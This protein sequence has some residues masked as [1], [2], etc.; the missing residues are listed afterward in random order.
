MKTALVI[1]NG[2]Q[3]PYYLVDHAISWA[4]KNDGDLHGLFVY[5]DKEPREGYIFPSDIDPAENLYN[6]SD[7]EQV[8]VGVIHAQI[9]LFRD[10]A[11]GK[12]ISVQTEELISPSLED[13][14]EI[15]EAASILFIDAVSDKSYLLACTSFDFKDLIEESKCPV[16]MVYDNR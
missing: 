10:M 1:F 13:I 11:K 6:K 5:S 16:E 7:A 8:N 4:A 3:F 2:I 14:L 9:K 12:N 15:T